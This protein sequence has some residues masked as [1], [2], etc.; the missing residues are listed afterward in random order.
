MRQEIIRLLTWQDIQEI[1]WETEKVLHSIP[2]EPEKWPEWANNTSTRFGEALKVLRIANGVPPPIE[3]RHEH[4]LA[5]AERACGQSLT[6]ARNSQNTLIRCF[7]AY[8]LHRDGYS[9]SEIGKVM[10][11]DHSTITHLDHRMRDMLSIPNAYKS[12]VQQYKRF[13]EM[14]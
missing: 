4:V 5:C 12:E 2:D 11:R 6:S 8:Q 14:L 10:K 1:W 9:Y 7:V 3:E 13:E